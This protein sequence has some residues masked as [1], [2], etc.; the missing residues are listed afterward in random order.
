MEAG[1]LNHILLMLVYL[2]IALAAM[3]KDGL[4]FTNKTRLNPLPPLLIICLK[5]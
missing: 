1:K 2:S 4:K 5:Y 3:E